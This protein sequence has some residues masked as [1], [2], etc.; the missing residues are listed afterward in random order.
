MK[1]YKYIPHSKNM[2]NA[3][4]LGRMKAKKHHWSNPLD[5]SESLLSAYRKQT[6]SKCKC[7]HVSQRPIACTS[8]PAQMPASVSKA[9]AAVEQQILPSLISQPTPFTLIHNILPPQLP[10][11]VCYS[12]RAQSSQTMQCV[13]QKSTS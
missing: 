13:S 5:S 11:T 12:P 2:S 7:A 8:V 1:Y 4:W 9:W 6:C 10:S 3:P